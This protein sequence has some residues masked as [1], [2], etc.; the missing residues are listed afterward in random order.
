MIQIKTITSEIKNKPHGINSRLHV[1]EE[2]TNKLEDIEI[3]TIQN[4]T[5]KRIQKM[6]ITLVSYE[7][8]HYTINIS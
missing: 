1:A 3:E 4:K 2:K 5:E 6:K 8:F 7:T